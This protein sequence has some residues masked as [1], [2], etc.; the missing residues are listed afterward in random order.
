[1]LSTMASMSAPE[2]RRG[3]VVAFMSVLSTMPYD[4]A[5][6]IQGNLMNSV[7]TAA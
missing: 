6:T 1:M 2:G 4:G 7:R 5:E 3:F